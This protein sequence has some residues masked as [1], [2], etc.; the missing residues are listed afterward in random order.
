[1][2]TGTWAPPTPEYLTAPGYETY[3]PTKAYAYSPTG[4]DWSSA[5]PGYGGGGG[6]QTSGDFGGGAD[7]GTMGGL[8]SA[9][10]LL[11]GA[12]SLSSMLTGKSLLEHADIKSPFEN[13]FSSG[14]SGDGA[15]HS[16]PPNSFSNFFSP[17]ATKG[18]VGNTPLDR[19]Q[20]LFGSGPMAQREALTQALHPTGGIG[21]IAGLKYQDVGAGLPGAP[22]GGT[23][24][25]SPV[26]VQQLPPSGPFSNYNIGEP[27]NYPSTGEFVM[28]AQPAAPPVNLNLPTEVFNPGTGE[29]AYVNDIAGFNEAGQ[30][31]THTPS[32][33]PADFAGQF[34]GT[35]T[36]GPYGPNPA[37]TEAALN[38]IM[39]GYGTTLG[40]ASAAAGMSPG[41]TSAYMTGAIPEFAG[42]AFG[43]APSTG[44]LGAGGGGLGTMAA[45]GPLALAAGALMYMN[46]TKKSTRQG[47]LEDMP[48]IHKQIR[49]AVNGDPSM[50][51]S[52]SYAS[53]GSFA[54]ILDKMKAGDYKEFGVSLS[55]QEIAKVDSLMPQ[56]QKIDVDTKMLDKRRQQ[57]QLP[58]E[59]RGP[60]ETASESAATTAADKKRMELT[61]YRMYDDYDKNIRY[62]PATGQGGIGVTSGI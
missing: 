20:N 19:I 48:I 6:G 33:T 41:L 52:Q 18:I 34:Q 29:L 7:T 62:D 56:I 59:Y 45:M 28:P 8:L 13:L 49:D 60:P 27:F 46:S 24:P 53:G 21:D 3:A 44:L 54:T 5:Y 16:S 2:A 35:P 10:S 23:A 40:A 39:P 9:A 43:A 42:A 55:P 4:G 38:T 32:A 25:L 36:A 51:F 58:E 1:M 47:M 57:S 15:L 31:F 12:N 61:N 11:G 22:P 17:E 14:G 30:L 37:F 26:Q 50:L